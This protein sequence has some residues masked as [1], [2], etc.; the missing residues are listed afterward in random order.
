MA[1]QVSYFNQTSWIEPNSKF[2]S[3]HHDLCNAVSRLKPS[4]PKSV[5][6][7][8]N[9]SPTELPNARLNLK[10]YGVQ[11]TLEYYVCKRN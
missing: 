10:G 5:S 4:T 9:H 6:E 11:I 7:C 1:W 3:S 2:K 8:P